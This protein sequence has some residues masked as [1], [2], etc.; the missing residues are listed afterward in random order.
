MLVMK[1]E[2]RLG[3]HL[4]TIPIVC[5]VIVIFVHSLHSLFGVEG[6]VCILFHLVLNCHLV[7]AQIWGSNGSRSRGGHGCGGS[8]SSRLPF[9][10][11]SCCGHAGGEES[12]WRS[13]HMYLSSEVPRKMSSNWPSAQVFEWPCEFFVQHSDIVEVCVTK[14]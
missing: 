7:F 1:E 6:F 3:N 14:L 11:W 10:E 8:C 9:R 13:D 4:V 12:F 2:Y 5:E